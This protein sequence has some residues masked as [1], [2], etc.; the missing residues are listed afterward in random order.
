MEGQLDETDGTVDQFAEA[1]TE[2]LGRLDSATYDLLRMAAVL[3]ETFEVHDLATVLDRS[4][5]SMVRSLAEAHAVEILGE[6]G[7]GKLTFRSEALWRS[8]IGELSSSLRT[9][10]H[11]E[12]AEALANRGGDFCKVAAQLSAA[13]G[14]IEPWAVRWLSAV[15][16]PTL[17]QAAE[18]VADLLEA[19]IDSPAL[20]VPDRH[21]LIFRL[22]RVLQGMGDD[23]RADAL[24]AEVLRDSTDA[25]IRGRAWVIRI[26]AASRAQRLEES[27]ALATASLDDPVVVPG[28]RALIRARVASALVKQGEHARSRAEAALALREAEEAG[29]AQ[30]AGHARLVLSHIDREPAAAIAHLDAGLAGL[31][32]TDDPDLRILLLDN[33]LAALNNLGRAE[34]FRATA[35]QAP[36]LVKRGAPNRT[37]RLLFAAAMGSYDFGWWDEAL[38][39]L[40]RIPD[41]VPGAPQ[42]GRHGLAAMIHAHR[43][44]WD[45]TEWHLAVGTRIPVVSTDARIWSGYMVAADAMRAVTDGD[46]RKAADLLSVWLEPPT[47]FDG[48]ERFM[49]LPPL[50]RVARTLGDHELAESVVETAEKDAQQPDAPVMQRAAG[51]FGRAQIN[52]D[53]A[54]LLALAK[55]YQDHHWPHMR[56]F[57]IEEAAVHYAA[58]GQVEA[59][60][61]AFND[62]V[63]GY[64]ALGATWDV[65]R[66][67]ARLRPLGIRRGSR[68]LDQRAES[69]R[70][71]LTPAERRVAELVATGRSNPD[72][73]SLLFLSPRTVQTHVTHILRKLGYSSRT[74]LIRD[75][76]RR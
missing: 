56:A 58:A 23:A 66:V 45:Q 9:A 30:A 3:G 63:R 11:R 70:E 38:E 62:A 34:E 54:E 49:W 44:E 47:P 42:I 24:A 13:P 64:S 73:A 57:A 16:E 15:P 40:K 39:Y 50:V 17:S 52:G 8:L 71:A 20:P 29:D 1:I 4:A 7:D 27:V 51:R 41:E 32:A 21:E 12:F 60:R 31:G 33:R 59:A 65:R 28:T 55:L 67:D 2:R 14:P 69:G 75:A 74:D 61:V 68:T 36:A 48:R 18:A 25:R 5:S 6:T 37:S 53:T 72:V 22:M 46:L 43:E 10:L 35:H 76:G 26:V 19:A